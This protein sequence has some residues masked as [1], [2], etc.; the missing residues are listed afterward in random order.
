MLDNLKEQMQNCARLR[1]IMEITKGKKEQAAGWKR[2]MTMKKT[3]QET[4]TE[5]LQNQRRQTA[6]CCQNTENKETEGSCDQRGSN[7]Y[8]DEIHRAGH[9][10]Y[11]QKGTPHETI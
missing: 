7:I 1:K 6:F 11:H 10:Q 3:A 2:K 5:Q 8:H 4:Q 9:K